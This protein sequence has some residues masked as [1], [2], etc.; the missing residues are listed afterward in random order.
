MENDKPKHFYV[1]RLVANAFI[2]NTG[3][4]PEVNHIDN[5]GTNNSVENLEWCTRAENIKHSQNQ[6]RMHSD[7]LKKAVQLIDTKTGEAFVFDS[8]TNA[9]KFVNRTKQT[10]YGCAKHGW[11]A[12]GK[13]KVEYIGGM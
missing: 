5:N 4:K 8:I 9:A 13:Y 2:P 11:M 1:H 12:L 3:G 6:G 7:Y 10:I